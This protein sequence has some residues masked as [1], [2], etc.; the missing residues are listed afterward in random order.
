MSWPFEPPRK[1]SRYP[2]E[3][4]LSEGYRLCGLFREIILAPGNRTPVVQPMTLSLDFNSLTQST[5]KSPSWEANS[6]S[7]SQEVPR[8][9]WNPKV[10]HRIY[11]SPPTVPIPN[12]I[13]P[14]HTYLSTSW[15]SIL[16]LSA[17]LQ[18]GF[19]SGLLPSG[20]PTNT[21]CTILLSPN[22]CYMPR[23]AHSAWFDHPNNIWWGVQI[24]TPLVTYS[25]RRIY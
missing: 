11:N 21:L 4:Q 1:E 5:E 7:A 15:R 6:Y 23:P 24:I 2:V 8:I 12:H 3:G 14:V 22:M 13:N 17:H 19:P 18:F 20:L 10:Y 25:R 16:I 9:L